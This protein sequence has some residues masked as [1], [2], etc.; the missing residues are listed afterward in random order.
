MDDDSRPAGAEPEVEQP[1]VERPAV[2][3]RLDPHS[4]SKRP[5]QLAGLVE[6][7][8]RREFPAAAEIVEVVHSADDAAVSLRNLEQVDSATAE[9]LAHRARVVYNDFMISPWY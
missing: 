2:E 9:K 7:A 6:S 4:P 1:D 8:L 3:F 5:E